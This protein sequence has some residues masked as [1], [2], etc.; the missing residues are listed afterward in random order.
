M[1]LK[2]S[3]RKFIAQSTASAAAL[4]AGSTII[5][6]KA[7]ATSGPA[8]DTSNRRILGANDRINFGFIG[9]GGRMGAHTNNLFKRQNSL[10]DVQCVAICDIY[11]KNKKRGK[12]AVHFDVDLG[13]KAMVA[14][15]L[16]VDAYRSGQ[17]M[18]FDRAREK[19][20]NRVTLA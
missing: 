19:A 11:E 14:I 13:Y 2:T 10:D 18:Y 12:E 17:V 7:E 5:K 9:M 3:R 6:A 1:S 4:T 16:G 15:R 20:T 8:L